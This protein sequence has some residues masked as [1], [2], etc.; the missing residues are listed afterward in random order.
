MTHI[1]FRVSEIRAES[2]KI[3]F[4]EV[5]P[6]HLDFRETRVSK[7]STTRRGKATSHV[8]ELSCGRQAT[9]YSKRCSEGGRIQCHEEENHKLFEEIHITH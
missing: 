3:R 8:T 7:R 9:R 6:G 5:T 1:A 2:L 4:T